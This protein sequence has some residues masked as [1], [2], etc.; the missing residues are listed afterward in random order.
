MYNILFILIS[1]LIVLVAIIM[2]L[3]KRGKINILQ[4]KLME[5]TI[6]GFL[7]VTTSFV[8]TILTNR[9]MG[10]ILK[11]NDKNTKEENIYSIVSKINLYTNNDSNA[12]WLD[13]SGIWQDNSNEFV[14]NYYIKISPE[15]HELVDFKIE[16][17]DGKI[18]TIDKKRIKNIYN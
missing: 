4:S 12:I 17:M 6:L 10:E 3:I 13:F 7:I 9:G 18:K 15:N 8:L 1:L 16:Y 2:W 5:L 14:K 11:I